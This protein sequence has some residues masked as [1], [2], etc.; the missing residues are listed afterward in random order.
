V[1]REASG[2]DAAITRRGF[3]VGAAGLA[4]GGTA[5]LASEAHAAGLIRAELIFRSGAVYGFSAVKITPVGSPPTLWRVQLGTRDA[6]VGQEVETLYH[7]FIAKPLL[8]A[9]HLQTYTKTGTPLARY[10]FRNGFPAAVTAFSYAGV[11]GAELLAYQLLWV[12]RTLR[13]VS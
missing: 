10:A 6:A 13:K 2:Q 3:V 7:S 5:F 12:S 8:R 4:V 1:A 9:G 11:G